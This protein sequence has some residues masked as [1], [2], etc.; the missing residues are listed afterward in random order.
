MTW[1]SINKF[2]FRM[3]W[4]VTCTRLSFSTDRKNR[5]ELCTRAQNTILQCGHYFA[6][7]HIQYQ[8]S[9]INN[10]QL[11]PHWKDY[12]YSSKYIEEKLKKKVDQQWYSGAT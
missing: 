11:R 10:S 8:R 7:R 6:E 12:L 3:Y 9:P 5:F 4:N 1:L 2:N